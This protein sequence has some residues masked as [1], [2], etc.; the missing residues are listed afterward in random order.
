MSSVV[1]FFAKGRTWKRLLQDTTLQI[2]M[3]TPYTSRYQ[4]YLLRKHLGYTCC[5]RAENIK[6]DGHMWCCFSALFRSSAEKA[7]ELKTVRYVRFIISSG[8]FMT[9]ML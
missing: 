1:S 5:S 6:L 9:T 7:S 3:Q 8:A 2:E 4:Q